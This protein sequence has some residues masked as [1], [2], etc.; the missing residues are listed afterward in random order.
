[1]NVQT[2][3]IVF[4]FLSTMILSLSFANTVS[5]VEVIANIPVGTN[6]EGVAYD[7]GLGEIFVANYGS[8]SVSVISDRTS[9][10]VA[11]ITVGVNPAG[12]AY[13]SV[14]GE[15][16]GTNCGSGTVSVI[17]DRNN[18]VI[19]N[20]AVGTN[21]N[22]IAYDSRIGKVFVANWGSNTVSVISDKNNTVVATV[23]VGINPVGVEFDSARAEVFVA[24]SY[25]SHGN[26]GSV[27]VISDETNSVVATVPV[28]MNPYY[29][30]LDFNKGE[31]Y[32]PNEG[33]GT[34]SIISDRTTSVVDSVNLTREVTPW[35]LAYDSQKGVMFCT[36]GDLDINGTIFVISSSNHS[37]IANITQAS[38]P[39]PNQ[40]SY[41]SPLDIFPFYR[42]NHPGDAKQAYSGS[43]P[44][45]IV[46]DSAKGEAYVANNYSGNV[47]VISDSSIPSAFPSPTATVPEFGRAVFILVVAMAVVTFCVV[48]FRKKKT[49]IKRS[50]SSGAAN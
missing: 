9:T 18:T 47:T 16:F 17:L 29:P 35:A 6:P 21:P 7:I 10:V 31:I 30:A 3:T 45:G 25:F 27:S 38:I 40:V 26:H 11:N 1:M 24:N 36:S 15:I 48:A 5:A 50:D 8:N 20:V 34:I 33:D 23:P 12:L 28:G 39:I 22:G 32:V 42:A 41:S 19:A 37:V 44:H 4:L 49:E 13:D 46:Y 14:M 2:K 43:K